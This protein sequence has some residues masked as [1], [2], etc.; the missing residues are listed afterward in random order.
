MSTA[1]LIINYK[2]KKYNRFFKFLQVLDHYSPMNLIFTSTVTRGLQT[3]I[4]NLPKYMYN[5]PL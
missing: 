3:A 2:W 4:L 5:Y 1:K